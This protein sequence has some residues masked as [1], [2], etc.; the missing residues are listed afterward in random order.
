MIEELEPID[1]SED[2]PLDLDLG[3]SFDLADDVELAKGIGLSENVD[4][5]AMSEPSTENFAIVEDVSE[6]PL[7]PPSQPSAAP[8]QR[9]RS[10]QSASTLLYLEKMRQQKA[11]EVKSSRVMTSFASFPSELSEAAIRL[12]AQPEHETLP[13]AIRGASTRDLVLATLQ[14]LFDRNIISRPELLA[15]L[16]RIQTANSESEGAQ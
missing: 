11:Q 14:V 7:T 9:S 3:D 2:V 10:S 13:P 16:A 6:Q 1:E 12:L 8:L 4:L 5:F 15:E